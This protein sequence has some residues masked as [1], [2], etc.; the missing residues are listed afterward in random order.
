[1]QPCVDQSSWKQAAIR[2][3]AYQHVPQCTDAWLD[4]FRIH[5]QAISSDTARYVFV[6]AVSG[7]IRDV[8]G[9]SHSLSCI[10][11]A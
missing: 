5:P 6:Q 7:G 2:Q 11:T 10:T 3:R 9:L 4:V 8:M 1:M